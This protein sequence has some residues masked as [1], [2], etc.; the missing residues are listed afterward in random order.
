MNKCFCVTFAFA[1]EGKNE[2]N[3]VAEVVDGVYAFKCTLN[4]L[5]ATGAV[6]VFELIGESN[7]FT[8]CVRSKCFEH[9]V[10]DGHLLCVRYARNKNET[11][12]CVFNRG[13]ECLGQCKL[14]T[15]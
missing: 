14:Q 2:M 4:S 8:G 12:I 11:L 7:G 13:Q 10:G 5:L 1:L 3:T 9:I 6:N 15:M